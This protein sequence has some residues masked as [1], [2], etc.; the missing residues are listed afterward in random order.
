MYYD[1]WTGCQ[2]TCKLDLSRCKESQFGN[3]KEKIGEFASTASHVVHICTDDW[4]YHRKY[5]DMFSDLIADSSLTLGPTIHDPN[6]QVGSSYTEGAK[7]K[8]GT[9]VVE[10]MQEFVVLGLCDHFVGTAGST[11]THMC[12][13]FSRR[14]GPGWVSEQIIGTYEV[15]TTPTLS[16]RNNIEAFLKASYGYICDPSEVKV[17]HDQRA[18]LNFLSEGHLRDMYNEIVRTVTTEGS[19]EVALASVIGQNLVKNVVVAR[20]SKSKYNEKKPAEGGQHWLTALLKSKMKTFTNTHDEC[21]YHIDV[22]DGTSAMVYL[23]AK[24]QGGLSSALVRPSASSS[25]SAAGAPPSK[26]GRHGN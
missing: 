20:L 18:V 24:P 13:A 26:R 15:P 5:Y 16:F 17:S 25:S 12:R 2:T 6:N 21:E 8:R 11:V 4:V 19:Q 14:Y 9:K 1:T 3:N 10:A 23:L 22:T 7:F